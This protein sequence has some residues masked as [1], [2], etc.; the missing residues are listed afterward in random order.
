MENA[1]RLRT[2]G[3]PCD[4][5]NHDRNTPSEHPIFFIGKSAS[6]DVIVSIQLLYTLIAIRNYC[7]NK[8]I[9]HLGIDLSEAYRAN[10]EEGS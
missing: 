5:S 8:V 10:R 6:R 4:P 2:V 9:E 7:I 1:P 3:T